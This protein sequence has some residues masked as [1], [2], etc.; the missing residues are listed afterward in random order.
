MND[1]NLSNKNTII[2]KSGFR[3]LIS[4]FICVTLYI[5]FVSFFHLVFFINDDENIMYT[6]SGYY[7]YGIPDDHPFINVILSA[8]LRRLYGIFPSI[9]WYSL[10]HIFIIA[11]SI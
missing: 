10:F 6:L 7:T 9:Q 8:I 4:L 5:S 11:G 3:I 1:K 2:D